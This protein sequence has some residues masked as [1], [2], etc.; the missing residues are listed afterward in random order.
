[1]TSI[2]A[3]KLVILTHCNLKAKAR[4]SGIALSD[5]EFCHFETRAAL[6][7]IDMAVAQASVRPASTHEMAA[8]NGPQTLPHMKLAAYGYS[9]AVHG[10]GLK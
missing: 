9:F 1:M 4:F 6:S 8:D 2:S 3:G 5:N 10:V 7:Q